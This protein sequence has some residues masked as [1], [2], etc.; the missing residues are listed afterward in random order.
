MVKK[1][2]GKMPQPRSFGF[3]PKSWLDDIPKSKKKKTAA[4]C[5]S[6]DMEKTADGEA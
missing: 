1:N 3:Q 5:R 2:C 6:Y 4:G